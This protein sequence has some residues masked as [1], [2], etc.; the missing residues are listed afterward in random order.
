MVEKGAVIK[1]LTQ[2]LKQKQVP[3]KK[4][5]P[6]AKIKPPVDFNKT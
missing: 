4:P 6:Q 1:R 3:V 5:A 2:E